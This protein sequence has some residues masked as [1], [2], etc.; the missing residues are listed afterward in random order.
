MDLS[1]YIK[2][3]GDMAA[4]NLFGVSYW[5]ARSWRLGT[6]HPRGEKAR[7]IVLKTGG[8][9]TFDSIY[10]KAKAA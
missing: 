1:T 8:K 4:A 6:R 10:A 5:T 3:M 9:V 2:N 7:E